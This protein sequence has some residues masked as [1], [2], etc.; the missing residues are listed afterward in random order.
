MYEAGKS[1]RNLNKTKLKSLSEVICKNT[2]FE[3]MEL[4][5]VAQSQAFLLI[6]SWVTM[7]RCG[8]RGG[9]RIS[10]RPSTNDTLMIPLLSLRAW[11]DLI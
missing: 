2:F 9:Q 1:F 11:N 4:P 7:K 8:S 3:Q 5:W 6:Y 10:N